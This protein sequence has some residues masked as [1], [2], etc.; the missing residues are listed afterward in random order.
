MACSSQKWG[1]CGTEAE[2]HG[3]CLARKENVCN[4]PKVYAKLNRAAIHA[5][6]ETFT[7]FK[8]V[9]GLMDLTLWVKCCLKQLIN[10]WCCLVPGEMLQQL[11]VHANTSSWRLLGRSLPAQVSCGTGSCQGWAWEEQPAYTTLSH[12]GCCNKLK[13]TNLS[14]QQS[15][16]CLL[17][18]LKVCSSLKSVSCSSTQFLRVLEDQSVSGGK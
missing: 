15:H 16:L 13:P 17:L 7:N 11:D 10:C 18:R 2:E 9:D 12:Q 14:H 1:C 3:I 8:W 4:P 6:K 5:L